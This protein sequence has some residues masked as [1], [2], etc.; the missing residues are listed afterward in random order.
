MVKEKNERHYVAASRVTVVLVAVLAAVVALS[1][2]SILF[3]FKLKIEL[4]GGLG[5]VILARWFWHRVNAWSE[6]TALI[7]SIG[8]SLSLYSLAWAAKMA[9]LVELSA[10]GFR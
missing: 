2:P 10:I 9:G 7:V 6:L 4:I 1:L 5:G 3:A 8:T